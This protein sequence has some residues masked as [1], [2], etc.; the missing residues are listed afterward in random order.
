MIKFTRNVLLEK[1]NQE[2]TNNKVTAE[3]LDEY[4]KDGIDKGDYDTIKINGVI[5]AKGIKKYKK[6]IYSLIGG[7]KVV[8]IDSNT[9]DFK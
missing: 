7:S 5:I 3:K 1:F 2:K 6:S 4:I 8:L 9:I